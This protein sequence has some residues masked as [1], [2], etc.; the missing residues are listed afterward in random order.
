MKKSILAKKGFLCF[1]QYEEFA[2]KWN[3]TCTKLLQ[4]Q[5]RKREREKIII[6][7]RKRYK[8]EKDFYLWKFERYKN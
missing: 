8:T 3:T 2:S 6:I 7:F 5:Y 1:E 4:L